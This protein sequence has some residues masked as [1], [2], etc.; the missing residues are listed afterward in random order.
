LLRPQPPSGCS[1][2]CTPAPT[3][4]SSP[5]RNDATFVTRRTLTA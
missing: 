4:R 3:S 2:A 5:G 1:H